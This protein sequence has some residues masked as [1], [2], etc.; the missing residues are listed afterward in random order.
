MPQ[1]EFALVKQVAEALTPQEIADLRA[2]FE[3]ATEN[4]RNLVWLPSGEWKERAEK[5]ETRLAELE[6]AI[7]WDT[8]CTSC[9]RILDS[10]YAETTRREAAEAKLAA[11]GERCHRSRYSP[12]CIGHSVDAADILAI[13]SSEEEAACD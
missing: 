9:A 13:I 7:T 5:A 2:R 6:N 1:D 11:I 3:A 8:S 4:P 12:G 10:A